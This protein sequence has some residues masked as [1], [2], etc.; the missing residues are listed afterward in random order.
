MHGRVTVKGLRNAIL[1]WC[2]QKLTSETQRH[3]QGPQDI[4]LYAENVQVLRN[5]V[6]QIMTPSLMSSDVFVESSIELMNKLWSG[7]FEYWV[8]LSFSRILRWNAVW[9][10]LKKL[11][12][13]SAGLWLA[14]LWQDV[15]D[16]VRLG[17]LEELSLP[18]N[19]DVRERG[20]SGLQSLK[21]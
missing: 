13:W 12:W 17:F 9:S 3:F 1:K 16:C 11:K 14:E 19:W 21:N 15:F 4:D 2:V 8:I 6:S 7:L 18:L 10:H 20:I 5:F